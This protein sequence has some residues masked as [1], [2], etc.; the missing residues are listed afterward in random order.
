MRYA[1]HLAEQGVSLGV[2]GEEVSERTY[3]KL[4][5]SRRPS[6]FAARI[7]AEARVDFD[8]TSG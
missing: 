8:A 2:R 4:S 5:N 7:T 6:G 3:N 1:P